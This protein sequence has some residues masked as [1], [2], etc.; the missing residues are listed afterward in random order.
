MS[1]T[2]RWVA[3]AGVLAWGCAENSAE[4]TGENAQSQE[5]PSATHGPSGAPVVATLHTKDS[6]LTITG[7]GG[8][9]RYSLTDA[10]GESHEDLTL[11]ELAAYDANLYE[12]VKSAMAANAGRVGAPFVDARLEASPVDSVVKSLTAAPQRQGK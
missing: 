8:N 10:D 2:M 4:N 11:D 1:W 12:V 3:L 9:V 6:E 5:L 7:H